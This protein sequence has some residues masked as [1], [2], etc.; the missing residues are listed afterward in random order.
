MK[1]CYTQMLLTGLLGLSACADHPGEITRDTEPFDGIAETATISAL[2]NEP[3]WSLSVEPRDGGFEATY[4]TP[5]DLEG[6][7]FKVSR[8]AGN[9][10]LGI[11]GELD[12]QPLQLALTPA[13]CSDGMSDRTYPYTATLAIGDETR[14]GCAYTS[15]EGFTG[16]E[17]P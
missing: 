11:G 14:F 5:D 2:G 7:V 10:G 15:D 3:F 8:F 9:N 12:G 17:N 1:R 13:P 6:D 16:D 4:S